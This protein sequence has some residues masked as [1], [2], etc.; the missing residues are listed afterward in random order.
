MKKMTHRILNSIFFSSRSAGNSDFFFKAR[1]LKNIEFKIRWVIFFIIA[2]IVSIFWTEYLITQLLMVF[3]TLIYIVAWVLW[4]RERK[5]LR[6]LIR[7]DQ[8]LL[9]TLTRYHERISKSLRLEENIALFIYPIAVTAGYFYGFLLVKDTESL[10]TNRLTLSI[11]IGLIIAVTP[12]AHYLS[13]WMNKKAY[14]KYLDQLQDQIN[15]LRS[16]T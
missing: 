2:F 5:F 15:L 3:M 16:E 4:Y 12:L 6:N 8:D 7:G 11:W 1:L 10:F 9:T 13:R 14:G